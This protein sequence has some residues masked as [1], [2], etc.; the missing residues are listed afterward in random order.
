MKK[1]LKIKFNATTGKRSGDIDPKDPKL[2]CYGWQEFPKIIQK[3][4]M[5]YVSFQYYDTNLWS[6]LS[7]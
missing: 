4:A 3:K 2:Q 1:A 7:A 5:R 6:V